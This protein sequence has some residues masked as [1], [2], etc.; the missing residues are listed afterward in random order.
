MGGAE[1]RQIRRLRTQHRYAAQVGLQLHQRRVGRRAAVD[2]QDAGLAGDLAYRDQEVVDLEGNGLEGGAGH[3]LQLGAQGQAGQQPRGAR[4]PPGGAQPVE[5]GDEV[6]PVRGRVR[7]ERRELGGRGRCQLREP[8][9]GRAAGPDVAF[10]GAHGFRPELPGDR[11]AQSGGRGGPP[12]GDRHDGRSRP[13]GG[14][15]QAVAPARMAEQRGVRVTHDGQ[16][17]HAGREQRLAAVTRAEGADGG[18]DV[19]EGAG[20][21]AEQVEEPGRPLARPDVHQ[22]RAR[23]V[24]DLDLV[25]A[26]QPVHEPRVDGAQAQVAARRA[27]RDRGRHGPAATGPWSRRTSGPGAARCCAGPRR[28]PART[29]GT[30]RRCAGPA[31]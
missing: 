2:G 26:R 19:R 21:H 13:V 6:N 10:D 1:R 30:G 12:A 7:R 11:L 4:V 24:A 14:L 18:D 17:R 25:L 29:R 15:D 20:G 8:G 22:L 27:E 28:R 16:D 5:A 9:Q 31:S 3:V 23:G